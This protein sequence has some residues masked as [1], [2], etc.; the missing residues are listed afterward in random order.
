M[1]KLLPL[2]VVVAVAAPAGAQAPGLWPVSSSGGTCSMVQTFQ[3]E[4]FGRHTLRI[5]F[6][7]ARQELTVTTTNTVSE[8]LPASGE[9]VWKIVFL[10]NGDQKWDEGW[11]D[12]HFAYSQAGNAFRFAIG[13]AG[14]NNVRQFLADLANSSSIGFLDGD[15]VVV[16]YDLADAGPSVAKLRDCAA[17]ALAAN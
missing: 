7:Q 15:G 6:D 5:G 17:R 8:P 3:D 2:A 14:E 1:K 4:E 10:D 16:A 13:L 9:V 12:R 11:S